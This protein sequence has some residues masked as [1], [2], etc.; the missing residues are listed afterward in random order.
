MIIINDVDSTKFELNGIQYFKNFT[1]VVKGDKVMIVNTYDARTVLV[2]LA[3]FSEFEIDSTT[4]GTVA[5][6][7]TALLPVI[8]TRSNLGSGGTSDHG[9][10]SGLGDDDHTQYLTELRHDSLPSD[11]PH[12]VTANQVGLGNVDNTSDVNKP[13]STAQQAY[14]DGKKEED[15][16]GTAIQASLTGTPTIALSNHADAYYT[17]TG[18]TTIAVSNTP[19][20]DKSFVR[21]WTVKSTATETLTLP[22]SWIVIGEYVADGSENYLTIRFSNY[23]TAGAKVVC[24]INQDD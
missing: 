8:F 15:F 6:V 11:N 17:L 12:G 4:Y 14:I 10:L 5:E 16:V 24:W 1:P 21:N 20:A 18:N 22:A 2:Q 19:A 23:T 3:D 7:Q 13:L 9:A